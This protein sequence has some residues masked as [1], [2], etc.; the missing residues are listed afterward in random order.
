MVGSHEKPKLGTGE[1]L[2]LNENIGYIDSALAVV[3]LL[4]LIQRRYA[5][6]AFSF[7]LLP[8]LFLSHPQ[9]DP[10]VA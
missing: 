6:V 7:P 2:R 10:A 9:Y 5:I 1:E 3:R 4:T 8:R